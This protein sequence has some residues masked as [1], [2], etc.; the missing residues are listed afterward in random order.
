MT[1][2][3]HVSWRPAEQQGTWCEKMPV[4]TEF[5]GPARK[6]P[7]DPHLL[8]TIHSFDIGNF[9]FEEKEL[10]VNKVLGCKSFGKQLECQNQTS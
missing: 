8:R 9:K 2:L 3:W 4:R 5:A 6:S 7:A 1:N 10:E